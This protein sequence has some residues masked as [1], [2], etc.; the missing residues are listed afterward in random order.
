MLAENPNDNILQQYSTTK[1][2]IEEINNYI[3]KGIIVR[4]KAKFIE[5]NEASTKLFLGLEKSKAKTKNIS[6]L[7]IDNN[8]TV[9]NSNEILQEE[10]KYYQT[11]YQEQI[12]Y[13]DAEVK[14]AKKY[15]LD[16]LEQQISDKDKQALDMSIYLKMILQRHLKN[17]RQKK[18]QELMAYP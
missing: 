7:I 10:K 9:T 18:V 1:K 3:T 17:S 2:E 12:N 14:E 6:K 13:Q 15:F 4:A 11:L 5:Q 16:E 8:T